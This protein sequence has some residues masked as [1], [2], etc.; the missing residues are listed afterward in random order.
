MLL[1]F[2][3]S[4]A[5]LMQM[6]QMVTLSQTDTIGDGVAFTLV[7]SVHDTAADISL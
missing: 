3:S 2:R 7:Y 6:T 1:I 4:Q 5:P